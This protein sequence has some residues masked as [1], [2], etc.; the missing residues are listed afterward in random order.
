MD[1]PTKALEGHHHPDDER[2]LAEVEKLVDHDNEKKAAGGG[3]TEP[4]ARITLC[5][6]LAKKHQTVDQFWVDVRDK[7][8]FFF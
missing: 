8:K 5:E 1:S 4:G 2:L 3:E 7:K 6:I